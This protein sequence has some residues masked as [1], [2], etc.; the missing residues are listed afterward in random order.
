MLTL[1]LSSLSIA[2]AAFYISSKIKDDVF[3]TA[4]ALTA[5]ALLLLNL[6]LGPW[7]LKLVG[8]LIL[9]ACSS[10]NRWSVKNFKL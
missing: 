8:I 4:I 9:F 3:S 10:L 5:V 2:I 6:V 1:S 7:P